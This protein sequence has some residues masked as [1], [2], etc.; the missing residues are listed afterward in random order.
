MEMLELQ[1]HILDS[2]PVCFQEEY[3]KWERINDFSFQWVLVD[4][5][6]RHHMI[7]CFLSIHAAYFRSLHIL[8]V[9]VR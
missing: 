6:I 1:P 2:K 4:V 9:I 7:H 8:I 5:S 3:M